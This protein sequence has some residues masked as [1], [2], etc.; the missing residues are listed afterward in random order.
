MAEVYVDA[1]RA[2]RKLAPVSAAVLK[3]LGRVPFAEVE[4]SRGAEVELPRWAAEVLEERGFVEIRREVKDPGDVGRVKFSEE[5]LQRRGGFALAR[6]GYDFY[7]EAEDLVR[8]LE[9]RIGAGGIRS[10]E[11]ASD[12]ERLVKSLG[13]VVEMR[14]QKILFAAL[15]QREKSQDV[16]RNMSSE[17]RVFYR[18]VSGDLEDF[19]KKIRVGGGGRG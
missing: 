10:A 18:L 19:V 7:L 6:V 5:D 4:L 8:R 14:V 2:A 13:R 12:L 15:L 16:E 9:T 11:A 3:S 17:E 1:V